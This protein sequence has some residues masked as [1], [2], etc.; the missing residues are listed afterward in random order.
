M[1][2]TDEKIYLNPCATTQNSRCWL[3]SKKTDI[4]PAHLLTQHDKFARHVMVTAGVCF[5]GR[6]RLHF[7]VEK[8]KVDAAYYIGHLLPKLIEDCNQL[9]PGGFIFQQDGVEY[10]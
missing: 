8:A 9:L 1:F 6:G 4:K 10:H 7:V 5:G 3:T 2:F